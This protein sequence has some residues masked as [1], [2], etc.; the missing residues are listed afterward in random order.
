M[1][2]PPDRRNISDCYSG[3][4]LGE[5]VLGVDVSGAMF[6]V[7]F[8]PLG[9]V[10]ER[11]PE[12][13]DE[14]LLPLKKALCT[15][16]RSAS[17]FAEFIFSAHFV[18]SRLLKPASVLRHHAAFAALVVVVLLAVPAARTGVTHRVAPAMARRM[19]REFIVEPPGCW[20]RT[21]A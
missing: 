8:V 20:E 12:L 1:T 21:E 14:P 7:V 16:L 11:P 18:A 15:C 2:C 10:L 9:A 6:G 4:L 19:D 3:A 17:V 13:C 5:T